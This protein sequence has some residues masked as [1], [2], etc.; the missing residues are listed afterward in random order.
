MQ[1]RSHEEYGY[2][3]I[4]GK[5][6]TTHTFED[7]QKPERRTVSTNEPIKTDGKILI[8]SVAAEVFPAIVRQQAAHIV[9]AVQRNVG[10]HRAATS[11]VSCNLVYTRICMR[12]YVC[13]WLCGCVCACAFV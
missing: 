13:I 4:G 9:H 11:N 10:H 8:T 2:E 5:L 12:I 7:R 3:K 1:T 6:Y